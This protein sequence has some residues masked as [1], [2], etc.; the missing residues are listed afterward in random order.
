VNSLKITLLTFLYLLLVNS[1]AGADSGPE[2]RVGI[3][4]MNP[5]NFIDARGNAQGLYPDLL[6]EIG[7]DKEWQLRFVPGSWPECYD[8]LLTGEI[9]LIVTVAYSPE[10]AIVFDYNKEPVADIWGK[11]YTLPETKV[12]NFSDLDRAKV[13]V[14]S[15]DINA[16]NF[17]KTAEAFN[18][19]PILTE[20]N[21]HHDIFSAIQKGEVK[22]GVV[23]QHFGFREAIK[24]GLVPTSI[25]F[26]PFSV[27]FAAKKGTMGPILSHIDKHLTAWKSEPGSIYYK[28]LSYWMGGKQFTR[29]IVPRWLSATLLAF[30]VGFGALATVSF[31]LKRQVRLRTEELSKREKRFR[32]LAESTK[33]VPWEIDLTSHQF[34]YMGPQIESI[35]GYPVDSWTDCDLWASRIHPDDRAPSVDYCSSLT[36]KGEDH[37]LVYRAPHQD[38][39]LRWIHDIVSIVKGDNGAEKLYG[40]FIDITDIKEKER[41]L[42]QLSR[43]YSDIANSIG[44]WIWEVDLN[45]DYTYSSDK[46]VEVI[47]YTV[48]ELIGKSSFDFMIP[49]QVIPAKA[50]FSQQ[51]EKASPF[52]NYEKLNLHKNGRKVCLLSSGVPIYHEDGH[53]CGYRGV[54]S[55]ITEQLRLQSQ[56]IRSSQLATLGEIAAGVAHEINN[57]IGGVINYAVILKKDL[58]SERESDLLGR[59]IKE[60]ERIAEIVRK[61]LQFSRDEGEKFELYAIN[62]LLDEP[63]SLIGSQLRHDNIEVSVVI[64]KK[65]NHVLCNAHQIEQII[66]NML[67]NAKYALNKKER[68]AGENKKISITAKK[69]E[70]DANACFL[71]EITDNG[72][73]ISADNLSRVMDPFYSTKEPGAGTGLGLSLSEEII[74][75]HGG[76][77]AIESELNQYTKVSIEIPLDV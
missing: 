74:Q 66:L 73:G 36:Q 9:D 21:T 43:R 16:K 70:R 37:D 46:S 11:V 76:R 34:T 12:S 20:F 7:R 4:P 45:G 44:D 41:N 31:G 14:V 23:P 35:L 52:K 10:R 13:G 6:R 19:N 28:K 30:I 64:D 60:G 71:L 2:I 56:V 48:D 49:D 65:L 51:L 15:K 57:P 27:F 24:Y 8:R 40:Y 55:D 63:L 54:D 33:A 69:I 58:K 22:A 61:L 77:I 17:R 5:L 39:S 26:E 50:F 18:L 67:S 25:E 29:D 47:G 32:T 38:G 59:I 62:T 42:E 68:S 75:R 53:L 72:I 3:F 1:Y